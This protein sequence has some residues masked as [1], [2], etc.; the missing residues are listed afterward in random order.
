MEKQ[1]TRYDQNEMI[2]K[3][4]LPYTKDFLFISFA[5]ERFRI[6]RSSGKVELCSDAGFS[7]A[8]FNESMTIFDVLCCSKPDCHLSGEFT[9]VTN[10]PGIAKTSAPGMNLYADTARFFTNRCDDLR[11]ACMKLN[12][13]EQ[14]VGD[15]SFQI[16][17]FDFLPVV[18]QFWDADDEFDACLKIMWDKNTLD[19]LHFESTFYAMSHLLKRLTDYV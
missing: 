2:R 9:T 10:L 7:H 3:F 13:V 8:G 19:F 15:V 4:R 16:P 18:L 5:G 12:G 6:H 17:L 14:A 11:L 1:F